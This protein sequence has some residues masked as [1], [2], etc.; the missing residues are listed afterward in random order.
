M[1]FKYCFPFLPISRILRTSHRTDLFVEVNN[2]TKGN[3]VWAHFTLTGYYP[4]SIHLSRPIPKENVRIETSCC[5][6]KCM[7]V[8]WTNT[9]VTSISGTRIDMT[10]EVMISTFM[11]NDLT[12]INGDHFEINLVA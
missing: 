11:D 4:T 1:L 10:T 6:F 2:L 9:E 5:I 12:H 7:I 8:D 3:T